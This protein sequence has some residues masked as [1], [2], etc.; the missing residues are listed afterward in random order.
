M[1]NDA[2]YAAIFD[3][4]RRL[5][6]IEKMATDAA[7]A[8]PADNPATFG[9]ALETLRRTGSASGSAI[10]RLREAMEGPRAAPDGAPDPDRLAEAT[11]RVAGG[12][13][14]SASIEDAFR[15]MRTN[16]AR[17]DAIET[18]SPGSSG[19]IDVLSP[20]AAGPIDLIRKA[21]SEE[22]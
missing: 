14:G 13:S 18:V 12:M 10:D 19:R 7:Q 5:A 8:P 2:G 1:T 16:A 17:R 15:V 4:R 20:G 22:H 21:L 11:E 9:A 3:L 6:R